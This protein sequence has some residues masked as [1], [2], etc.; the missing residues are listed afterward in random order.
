MNL[1]VDALLIVL[2]AIYFAFEVTCCLALF[3]GFFSYKRYMQYALLL[4]GNLSITYLW[5]LCLVWTERMDSFDPWY[6]FIN[7]MICFFTGLL[8]LIKRHDKTKAG[9]YLMGI[10]AFYCLAKFLECGGFQLL[11]SV[12]S[13]PKD[14]PLYRA[15]PAFAVI[16]SIIQIILILKVTPYGEML[17]NKLSE[18]YYKLVARNRLHIGYSR[19]SYH[20]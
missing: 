3:G 17:F 18:R 13:C 1:L 9:C 15:Y 2:L 16:S 8:L 10:I 14:L 6:D 19:N 7:G 5:A 4:G 20:D 11:R 12:D